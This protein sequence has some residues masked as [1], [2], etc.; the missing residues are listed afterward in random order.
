MQKTLWENWTFEAIDKY[1]NILIFQY[2]SRSYDNE[3][4]KSDKT[5]SSI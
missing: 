1:I 4:Y 5:A 2:I 3:Y